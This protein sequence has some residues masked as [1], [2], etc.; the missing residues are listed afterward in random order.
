MENT[1]IG[2]AV[3]MIPPGNCTWM[4]KE[5]YWQNG[6]M[7]PHLMRRSFPE[8]KQHQTYVTQFF[9]DSH[10]QFWG[11]L[12]CFQGSDLLHAVCQLEHIH[13]LRRSWAQMRT[14]WPQC[15]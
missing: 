11:K 14:L 13:L 9:G 7:E 12:G 1:I 8:E 4:Q 2:A 15:V 3:L 6:N 5:K 10:L